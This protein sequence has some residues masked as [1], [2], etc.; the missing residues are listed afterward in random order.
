MIKIKKIL[1]WIH[2]IFH[3]D[4]VLFC[5]LYDCV[6]TRPK[7]ND[8]EPKFKLNSSMMNAISVYK[9]TAIHIVCNYSSF[10]IN[11]PDEKKIFHAFLTL[12]NHIKE[13]T[14]VKKVSWDVAEAYG[15][16]NDALPSPNML[17]YYME[18]GIGGTDCS[19][20]RCLFVGTGK[21]DY[22][23]AKAAH[24]K[25]CTTKNFIESMIPCEICRSLN[26]YK[27]GEDNYLLPCKWS[28]MQRLEECIEYL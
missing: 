24:V 8:I 25:Y 26:V 10:K 14:G 2:F 12:S 21:N 28:P 13:K 19:S 6:V 1:E 18:D 3:S 22:L 20:K 15:K 5:N 9:P 4:K 11:F 16:K 27:C 17:I 23:A 7:E